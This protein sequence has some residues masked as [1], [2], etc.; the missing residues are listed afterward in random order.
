MTP[1]D[2]ATILESFNFPVQFGV[3]EAGTP[4]I[5]TD[6]GDLPTTLQ[7]G[8]CD[9]EPT[10]CL[11]IAFITTFDRAEVPPLAE[12]LQR[13]TAWMFVRHFLD[14]AGVPGV[15]MD[16]SLI[17]GDPNF[18][19]AAAIDI[20]REIAGALAEG[21]TAEPSDEVM[22]DKVLD[23]AMATSPPKVEAL[24]GRNDNIPEDQRLEIVNLDTLA[25]IFADLGHETEP[26]DGDD[27]RLWVNIDGRRA[28]AGIQLCHIAMQHCGAMSL[29][30][31]RPVEPGTTL[32]IINNF[33]IEEWFIAVIPYDEKQLVMN[34]EVLTFDGISR[35]DM[36]HYVDIWKATVDAFDA[37]VKDSAQ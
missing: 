18:R 5:E 33:N 11:D 34:M 1:V 12:I 3:S 16:V 27:S 21:Y 35:V 10:T 26:I 28:L 14:D 23:S 4:T 9:G 17:S 37:F 36:A 25:A 8:D 15:E 29:F 6:F 32:E 19:F 24:L 30:M 7:L 20:W 13:N 22:S 31:V 2:I